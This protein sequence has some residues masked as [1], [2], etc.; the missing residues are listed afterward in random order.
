MVPGPTGGS[1]G[2][3]AAFSTL[4]SIPYSAWGILGEELAEAIPVGA[5][6][7]N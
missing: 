2:G 7:T 1:R 4:R 6:Y 3:S 5:G